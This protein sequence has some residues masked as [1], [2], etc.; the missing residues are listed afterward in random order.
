V[1]NPTWFYVGALYA[2]AVWL[3]RRSG[4]ELPKRVALFFYALVFV[5]L[6]EPL[7]QDFVNLPVDFLKTLPPWAYWTKD[8]RALNGQ[9]N[10]IV[11]QIVPWAHQA[12]EAWRS[13]SAP[14]WNHLSACGYPLLA[15]AQSSAL[16]PLRILAL[17]L[18]L[19]HAMTAEAAMKLLVASTFTFLWCR[20]RGY[21]ELASTIGG[22]AFG[23]CTFLIVWLHFPL[24][25]TASFVPAVFYL[26]DLVVERRTYARFVAAAVVWTCMLF[27]GHP[28]TVSHTFFVALLYVLWIV[29]VERAATWRLLLTLGGALAVSALLAMPLLAP[30]AEALPKSK[31]FQQL[32]ANPQQFEVPYSD[33][34]SAILLVQPRFFGTMPQETPWGPTHAESITAFA[35][36]LGVAAW[37]ALLAHVIAR[38]RWRSREAFFVIATLLLLGIILSW[39]GV[40]TAFHLVFRLAANARL[41]LML[42]LLLAVQT[43]AAVDLAER[44]RR[45]LLTGLAAASAL[46]LFL[47]VH[48][49]FGIP[50]HHDAA[51][52]AM[53]PS[54]AVLLVALVAAMTER[55]H[56]VLLALLIAVTAEVWNAAWDWNPTVPD[57]WMYPRVPIL[58]KLEELK[59]A[60]R[61]PFRIVASGPAFFPNV[62][63]LYG[64]EDVRA[65]DPMVNGRYVGL[66]RL[67][68][69]YD[70]D[71]YFA[72]WANF[73]RAYIDYLN[74]RYVLTTWAGT[75]PGRYRLLY[76]S[77]DGRIF[78]NP[79][80]LPRFFPVRNVIIIFDDNAF[81]EKLRQTEG[82]AHTAFIE[83]LELENRQMHD[84]FFK[85]RPPNAPI[86]TSEI[87]ESHPT[88]YRLHVKAPRYTLMVSSIPWWPGWKVER[89]GA[90]ID[91]IR[92][93]GGFLGFAVPPGEL[94][95]RVWYDPWTWKVGWGVCGLTVA[96]LLAVWFARREHGTRNTEHGTERAA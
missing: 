58:E 7:T 95:V 63:A 78:E 66:L 51:V 10:D 36:Y 11:L 59:N 41:R 71:N 38:K 62:A 49:R 73:E 88:S 89:N 15:N 54:V 12:R 91:P 20:R 96:S 80:V 79:D 92:V 87:L 61:E 68:T 23:F 45:S 60:S 29:C 31:R 27:G 39:P 25:T 65:H 77:R 75:L 40:A 64:F 2:L 94:D 28:E 47:L 37:F 76:D 34:P 53:L 21:S 72:P 42:A 9:M 69:D 83:K 93:N 44:D 18:S 32:K 55:R 67:I 46:L 85:P 81:Y 22:V 48:T 43:A 33:F 50:Y 52:L 30:F 19:A 3:A 26:I 6:Y 86:A 57:K 8:H 1:F 56:W 70:A 24:A 90:R 74:V 16:S 13:L 84:D 17:P 5:Y 4:V 14:L 35:G 82:W